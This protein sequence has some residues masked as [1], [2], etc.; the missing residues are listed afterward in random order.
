MLELEVL[1]LFHKSILL[2]TPNPGEEARST[3]TS[4][5][6][7]TVSTWDSSIQVSLSLGKS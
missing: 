2:P 4:L 1:G 5:S 6:P 3:K 7:A